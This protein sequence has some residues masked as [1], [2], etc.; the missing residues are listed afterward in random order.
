MYYYAQLILYRSIVECVVIHALIYCPLYLCTL[1]VCEYA[2]E[3]Q[4]I[5]GL[6]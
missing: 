1:I 2:A 5:V 6:E 4:T 3:G